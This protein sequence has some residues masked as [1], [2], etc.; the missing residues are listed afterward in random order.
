VRLAHPGG[1]AISRLE[2]TRGIAGLGQVLA[3]EPLPRARL[4]ERPD[5][6]QPR[7][8][9]V[10][11]LAGPDRGGDLGDPLAHGVA[12]P[13]VEHLGE[14]VE[15]DP[16]VPVILDRREL[17][18]RRRQMGLDDLRDAQDGVVLVVGA[19]VE[20]LA[21]DALDRQVEGLAQGG[22]D[23]CDVHEWPPLAAALDGDATIDHRASR[24]GVDDEVESRPM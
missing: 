11:D 24:Q 8:P 16:V 6:A 17:D 9:D 12:R 4:D 14:L 3:P 23:V 13:E 22:R 20:D 19:E 15:R 5:V 1:I 10:R 7:I 2:R 21:T 18:V